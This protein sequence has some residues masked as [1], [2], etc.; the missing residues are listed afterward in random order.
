MLVRKDMY[1]QYVHDTCDDTFGV[2]VGVLL[3]RLGHRSLAITIANIDI[4]VP[5]MLYVLFTS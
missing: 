2:R 4:T 3:S 1:I 5:S